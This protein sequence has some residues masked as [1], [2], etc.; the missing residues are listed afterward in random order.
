M[1]G[2]QVKDQSFTKG[3]EKHAYDKKNLIICDGIW[4]YPTCSVFL[5]LHLGSGLE[6]SYTISNHGGSKLQR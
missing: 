6:K 5:S 4:F 2:S 3:V 1:Y